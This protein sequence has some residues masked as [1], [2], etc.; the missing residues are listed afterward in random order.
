MML[1]S[2][3]VSTAEID[4][5]DRDLDGIR[6]HLVSHGAV[7]HSFWNR[8]IKRTNQILLHR[9]IASR[10]VGHRLERSEEVDHIDG[11]PQNNKR[12]NLR[13]TT[14]RLNT[15]NQAGH[16]NSTSRYVGVYRARDVWRAFI[17][18]DGETL[19]IGCFR[20]EDEAAWMRDQWAL[21]MRG[22]YAR[23]NF[24]YQPISGGLV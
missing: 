16:G 17:C 8:A 11:N 2:C 14:H 9:I 15:L 21:S 23:L 20:D 6:W 24:D 18:Q 4:E 12:S 13:V 10:M 22:E 7:A 5:V 19:N 3:T 1:S